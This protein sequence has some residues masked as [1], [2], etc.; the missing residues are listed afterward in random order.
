MTF[1]DDVM[2]AA[3]SEGFGEPF[4]LVLGRKTYEIFAAHWP[5]IDND[6]IADLLNVVTKHVASRTFDKVEWNGA[7]RSCSAAMSHRGS[8]TSKKAMGRR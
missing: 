2:G 4:E 5:S 6:P 7:Q 3:M 1:W 8:D